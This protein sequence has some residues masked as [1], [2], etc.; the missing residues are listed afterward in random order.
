MTI[1]SQCKRDRGV[2]PPKAKCYV[3]EGVGKGK[4]Y[5]PCLPE[6]VKCAQENFILSLIW[7][8]S[9]AGCECS[10][11]QLLFSSLAMALTAWCAYCDF[12]SLPDQG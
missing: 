11:S 7:P 2:S 4:N 1:I 9:S 6:L 3:G 5:F 12:N 8:V 10:D